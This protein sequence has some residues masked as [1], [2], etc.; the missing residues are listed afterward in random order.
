[1][2]RRIFAD[3]KTYK[4]AVT[5]F[6]AGLTFAA[7]L[8][9]ILNAR[10]SHRGSSAGRDS[11]IL[12]IRYLTHLSRAL[13]DA[14]AEKR[15]M[16]AWQELGGLMMQAEAYEM[17]ARGGNASLYRTSR[18]SMAKVRDLLAAQGQV[19]RPPY[20]DPQT[21][22]FDFLQF[23]LDKTFRPAA[24]ILERQAVTKSESNFWG[25]QNEAYTTGLAVTTVAV[26]LLTL[27]LVMSGKARLV[28]AVAG[29][30][31]AAAVIA[32]S[33]A[34][35][36]R[37]WRA[38]ADGSVKLLAKAT[39]EM[40]RAQLILAAGDDL[41]AVGRSAD[42]AGADIEKVF[43]AD[44]GYGPARLLQNRV[45][46]VRGEALFF[47]GNI[48]EARHNF[49]RAAEGL[50]GAGVAAGKDG[51]LQWS[52]A[53][54]ELFFGEYEAAARSLDTSLAALPDRGFALE[55]L[56]ALALLARGDKVG[57]EAALERAIARAFEHPLASD[58]TDSRTLIKNFE[59]WNEL[60]PTDGLSSMIRRLKEAAVC[61]SVLGRARPEAAASEVT[62]LEF[63]ATRA[64]ANGEITAAS[65]CT[66]FPKWSPQAH[67]LAS[68]KGMKADE[69]I[70]TKVF[71]K[72]PGGAFWVEQFRLGKSQ[73]WSGGDSARLLGSVEYPMPEA[74]E[75]LSTGD[76]RLEIYVA[77]NLAAS[78]TFKVL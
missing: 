15:L 16:V 34:T 46:A 29:F 53:T 18:E 66:S 61:I 69:S 21:A 17:M 25:S 32:V 51:Y 76:Y 77:G 8:I 70:V 58:P 38:P 2:S 54:A 64:D 40:M 7:S 50:L 45:L 55:S 28:T 22:A 52:L 48:D 74:G 42:E 30:V 44:P 56:K 73:H 4:S 13:W 37:V 19:T 43:A 10:A 57:A 47:A 3:D 67:F 60:I 14:A 12:G 26:F 6:L 33:V 49:G 24:E 59:R 31:L 27:S 41:A 36:A 68:F 78:G 9:V 39:T 1:M 23:S 71:F 5:V 11:R 35:A 62:A 65:P 20:F 63:V 75:V 72:A